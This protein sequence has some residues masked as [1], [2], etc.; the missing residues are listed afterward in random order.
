MICDGSIRAWFLVTL[1]WYHMCMN[2]GSI[3]IIYVYVY[4]C[5]YMYFHDYTCMFLLKWYLVVI[6][7]LCVCM[8]VFGSIFMMLVV[9]I[10][11]FFCSDLPPPPG[12]NLSMKIVCLCVC[13][14][15]YSWGLWFELACFFWSCL[16]PPP[17]F[18]LSMKT[19]LLNTKK[20]PCWKKHHQIEKAQEDNYIFAAKCWK[21]TSPNWKNTRG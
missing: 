2:L 5:I 12:F 20:E 17:S 13:C 1:Y 6:G 14:L 18:N 10:S 3:D 21:Q 16:P 9:W 7:S 4:I 15:Q 19:Y 11:M 8:F